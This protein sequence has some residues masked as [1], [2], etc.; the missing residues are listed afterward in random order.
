M[1][2]HSDVDNEVIIAYLRLLLVLLQDLAINVKVISLNKKIE[3]YIYSNLK[4][5]KYMSPYMLF[6]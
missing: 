6:S 1:V 4:S 3:M 2:M 5:E